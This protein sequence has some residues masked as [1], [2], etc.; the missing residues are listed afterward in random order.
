MV[1]AETT[2]SVV[3]N[4]VGYCCREDGAK[5]LS[6]VIRIRGR[7]ADLQVFEETRGLKVGDP[8]EFRREMLSVTL[9]P[10]LLGQIYDGLQNPLPHVAEKQGF[11]LTPGVYLPG[12]PTDTKWPFTPTAEVGS[13]VRAGDTLGTVPEGIFEHRIMAPFGLKGEWKLASL[14]EAGEYTVE[15]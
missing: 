13:T 10:G 5:L 3:K 1:I 2:G 8:V 12:L 9:G 4:S 6:E 7:L 15:Q 11:F 14:A